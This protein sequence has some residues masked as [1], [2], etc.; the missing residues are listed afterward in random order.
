M[1]NQVLIQSIQVVDDHFEIEPYLGCF[2]N[3]TISHTALYDAITKS[4][5]WC[6]VFEV[7]HIIETINKSFNPDDHFTFCH[8]TNNNGTI[9][10]KL[11]IDV[12]DKFHAAYCKAKI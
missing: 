10:I 4:I 6:N 3:E 2:P 1:A 7:E 5:S 11:G 8:F 12:A 9:A